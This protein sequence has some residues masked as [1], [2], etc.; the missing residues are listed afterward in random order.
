M[1]VMEY[2]IA[3]GYID[4]LP[5]DIAPLLS[6]GWRPQGGC[7]MTAPARYH[8]VYGQLTAIVAQALIRERT[9]L[10]STVE[11]PPP[12]DPPTPE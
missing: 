7:T 4:K 6:Q 2:M 11:P 10:E 8:G 3:E 9:V 5:F 12:T 1:I